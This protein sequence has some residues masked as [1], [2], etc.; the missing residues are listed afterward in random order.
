MDSSSISDG[1]RSGDRQA[2]V[3]DSHPD[4]RELGRRLR[5]EL[6]ETLRAEQYAARVAARR[7]STLRD[8][9][10]LAE[11]RGE[12]AYLALAD[13]RDVT[14]HISAVG[15]DHVVITQAGQ[16]TWV[17]LNHIAALRLPP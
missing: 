14:G 17:A 3:P 15:A 4:L 16:G 12:R 1:Q 7:R 5:L 9:L 6:D 13:G 11:D 8:R 2:A 10:L